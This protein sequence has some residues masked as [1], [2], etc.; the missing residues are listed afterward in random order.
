MRAGV[1]A[2]VALVLVVGL[3]WGFA[4]ADKDDVVGRALSGEQLTALYRAGHACPAL[5]SARLAGQLMAESE[6]DPAAARTRS[7]GRG[8][9]GLTD[10][11]WRQ[12]APWPGAQRE[13]TAASVLALAHLMCNLVGQV[14]A[15]GIDGDGWRLALAAFLSGVATVREAGK[16]PGKATDYVGQA[17]KYAA[18]YESLP[19]FASP[20]STTFTPAGSVPEAVPLPDELVGAVVA[21]GSRCPEVSPAAIAGQLMALSGFNAEQRGT[22]GQ[23]GIAGFSDDLWQENAPKGASVWDPQQA[24]PAM[25]NA[26]CRLVRELTALPGD[27]YLLAAAAWQSGVDT[28]RRAGGVPDVMT[29][30]YLEAAAAYTEYYRLDTRLAPPSVPSPSPSSVSATPSVRPS[31][32]AKGTP[33]TTRGATKPAP[34]PATTAKAPA[35]TSAPTSAT[36]APNTGYGPRGPGGGSYPC[37]RRCRW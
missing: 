15:S 17:G 33:A 37:R 19:Q 1:A 11:Q 24:V 30:A 20:G 22:S 26:L 23:L 31:A 9:A 16:V 35:T 7:G 2:V 4:Y 8:I 12:W 5:T 21:A 28:V 34:P 32:P 18:Y 3:G 13:D 36:T 25:G 27:P 10:E 6:L 14:R 29:R